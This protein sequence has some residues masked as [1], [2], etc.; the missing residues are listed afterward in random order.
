MQ[1]DK[2]SIRRNNAPVKKVN[3]YPHAPNTF[4]IYIGAVLAPIERAP[5]PVKYKIIKPMYIFLF[6]LK[7]G[8]TIKNIITA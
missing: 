6:I 2:I 1:T 4:Y 3:S 8:L 5:T 7:L